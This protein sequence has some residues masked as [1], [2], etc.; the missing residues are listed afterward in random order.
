M[1]QR[2]HRPS[3][4]AAV[5]AACLLA[6]GGGTAALAGPPSPGPA[7]AGGTKPARAAARPL[8][9][10]LTADQQAALHPLAKLWNSLGE[11]HKRKWLALSG[12]FSRMSAE[13]QATLHSRMT[14]WSTLSPRQRA[15]ARLNFAEIRRLA[16]PDERKAKWEAYQALSEE[17]RRRL[18]ASAAAVPAT[19]AMPVRPVPARKLAPVPAD[20][21]HDPRSA[22]RI[23]LEPPPVQGPLLAPAARGADRPAR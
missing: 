1:P 15:R 5:L 11:A 6:F 17:E 12:N 14:E 20:A 2:M 9:H 16:P 13:E 22:P 19:T 7:K 21:L 4:R 23:Q 10:E 8:W 3:L 18:A